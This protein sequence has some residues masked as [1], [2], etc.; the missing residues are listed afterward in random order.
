MST[1]TGQNLVFLLVT[2]RKGLGWNKNKHARVFIFVFGDDFVG[3][4]QSCLQNTLTTALKA[5]PPQ[6]CLYVLHM[7]Q[8]NA[9]S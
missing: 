7:S 2:A 4:I 3:E 8:K 5:P 6:P 9:L 1:N